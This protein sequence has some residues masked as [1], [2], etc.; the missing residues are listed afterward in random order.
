V[1]HLRQKFLLAAALTLC[2]L[3]GA[4][5]SAGAVEIDLLGE[6]VTV[7]TYASFSSVPQGSRIGVAVALEM[8]GHWHVNAHEVN[9]EFLIPTTIDVEAPQGFTVVG[10]VYPEIV[11][12]E[13]SFSDKP[14]FLYEG[15]ALIGVLLETS[16]DAPVGDTAVVATVTYQACDNEKCLAPVTKRLEIPVRVSPP[17]EAID[18]VNPEVFSRIDFASITDAPQ[19]GGGSGRLGAVIAQRGYLI[20]FLLVFVWGLALNLT[21]CVYPIIPITVSYFGGQS[22]GRTSGTF[23]LA[24]VYVLGMAAM[25][26]SLGLVA[27]LTGSILGTILQNE[28]VVI[29]VALV[30]VGLALSMFGLYEIRVPDRLSNLAGGASGKQGAFGAFLMGLTVGIVAAPCIGPFV[31]ALLTF[32]GESGNPVLG[33]SMFFTLALGLGFPFL[34]LAVLSGNIARL[35]KSGEW[36]DWVKRLFGIVLIAMAIFFLQPHLE[37]I[38]YGSVIYW[39]SMGLLFVIGG[40]FLGFIR[41]VDSTALFFLVFRRFVGI[42]LPLFGLYLILTPGHILA[43]G[44]PEGGI[45]W[46]AYDDDLLLKAKTDKQYVLIDFSADWCLPCKEL[47]HKTF[48]EQSVVDATSGFVTLRADLT[49]AASDEV[50]ALRKQFEIRGVPTVIFIDSKGKERTD[51]RVFG[52]V[53]EEEFLERVGKLKRGT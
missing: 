23:L 9:D 18:A 6:P 43:T 46:T 42:A 3:A 51:L 40:V 22:E 19:G 7:R 26:S 16:P 8:K 32:V 36:M 25:Y 28:F 48:S 41:R 27:A 37:D 13:L 21:P 39:L 24:M 35:P 49:D 47:D 20:A 5:Q 52:F 2:V 31:L 1:I 38:A 14:L 12:K 34:F 10:T 4:P 15:E 17:T 53:D 45:A 33:F 30:L 44:A 11:E 50:L 29:V